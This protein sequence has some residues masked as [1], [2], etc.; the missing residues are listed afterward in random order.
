M[1]PEPAP[2]NY[3]RGEPI[4]EMSRDKLIAALIEIGGMYTQELEDRN[5]VENVVRR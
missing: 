3:W 2:M 1:N 4:E 5:S